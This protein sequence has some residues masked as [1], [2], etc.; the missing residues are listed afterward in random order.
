ML[1]LTLTVE[2]FMPY[3]G[4]HDPLILQGL[5]IACLSGENGAGKSA[6]LDAITWA[7]WGRSRAGAA[8]DPLVA[9]GAFEMGVELEFLAGGAVYRVERRYRKRNQRNGAGRSTFDFQIRTGDTWISRTGINATETGRSVEETIRLDYET[10][11]NTAFLVQGKADLFVSQ[12]PAQRKRIL[13]EILNL[14]VYDRLAEKARDLSRDD[15]ARIEAA[16]MSGAR[17]DAELQ[18]EAP[19]REQAEQAQAALGA[20]REQLAAA[21]QDRDSLTTRVSE[22]DGLAAELERRTDRISVL[23]ME[24]HALTSRRGTLERDMQAGEAL[25][26]RRE[27]IERGANDLRATREQLASHGERARLH[28]ELIEERGRLLREE[29]SALETLRNEVS[30]FEDRHAPLAEN[31]GRLPRLEEDLRLAQANRNALLAREAALAE[32]RMQREKMTGVIEARRADIRRLNSEAASLK[33]RLSIINVD[34]DARCPVCDTELGQ[35][36]MDRVR[37]HFQQRLY[38]IQVETETITTEGKS[39]RQEQDAFETALLHDEAA[40]RNETARVD[41]AKGGLEEQLRQARAA[42]DELPGVTAK[43]E[44]ARDRLAELP[45]E[46]GE[47]RAV[48]QRLAT[49]QY[50]SAEHTAAQSREKEL[51]RWEEEHSRLMMAAAKV[52][53]D[54][55]L[56]ADI[57]GQSGAIA[58]RLTEERSGV[59]KLTGPLEGMGEAREKA[60]AA[61]QSVDNLSQQVTDSDREVIRLKTLLGQLSGMRIERKRLLDEERA[62]AERKSIHDELAL[63]FSPQ[64][65]QALLIETAL[66]ELEDDA[67]NLLRR[68]TGNRMSLTLQTQR[69]TQAGSVQET[70]DVIIGDEWGTRPYEMYSGGE[71]FRI[72]FALRIALSKLLARRAGA[73]V[74]LLF[75]DEGFGSQDAEGRDR[76]MEAISILW[77]DPAYHDGLILVITHIEDIRNRFDARIDVVKTENGAS[78]SIAR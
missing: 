22:L 5:G 14:S 16:H 58:K 55:A 69:P 6:L 10:F 9:A 59:E 50:D 15:R 74:P 4:R 13:G 33:P 77:N 26:A 36:G 46:S 35:H 48:N 28:G 67:N 37:Q 7:L 41:S 52:E 29:Q 47:L 60:A 30:T 21:T 65:V 78:V 62:A 56:L 11:I 72:N 31:A 1:P 12:R 17:I 54:G 66:P 3:R 64:G 75:I 23:E 57:A 42:L 70:L 43:L 38:E 40:H 27:E 25:L 20:S 19:L 49:I 32:R 34:S 71:A 2:N 45:S 63:A 73:E 39:L 61:A 8:A 51:Q 68:M 18:Q 44:Q 24:A 53:R 76:L